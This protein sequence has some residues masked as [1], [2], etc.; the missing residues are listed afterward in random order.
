MILKYDFDID[1]N[2]ISFNLN[3]L[4]NQTY[5]LLPIREEGG[6]WSK[7]LATILEELSGMDRLLFD[8]HAILFPLICKL[9]GLFNLTEENDFLSYRGIIFECLNLLTELNKKCQD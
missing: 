5:K 9:E 1:N 7:P 6:D 8:Q 4:T 2:A 3:R